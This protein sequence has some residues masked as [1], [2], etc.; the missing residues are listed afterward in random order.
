M[1]TFEVERPTASLKRSKSLLENRTVL[2]NIA[3]I[4]I[5]FPSALR[6]EIEVD[7]V[8]SVPAFLMSIQRATFAVKRHESGQASMGRL[9]LQFVNQ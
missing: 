1:R 3:D 5:A 7:T 2:I 6:D 8:G 4:G 9:S